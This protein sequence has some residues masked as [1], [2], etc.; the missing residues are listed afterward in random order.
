MADSDNTSVK[1]IVAIITL[2]GLVLFTL[3]FCAVN[4]G[5]VGVVK[6][7]GAVQEEFMAEGL[8]FKTPFVDFV[9]EIDTRVQSEEGLC[10][11]SSKDLQ[12]VNT[13]VTV[14]YSL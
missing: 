8:N 7:L 10:V 1:V 4:A 6:R 9:E 14:Q 2:F 11:A 3:S 5:H 12:T 13:T